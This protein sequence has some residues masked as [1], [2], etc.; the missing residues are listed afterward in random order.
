MI[1]YIIIVI[2]I[3]FFTGLHFTRK[4]D[5]GDK[6]QVLIRW[7][8]FYTLLFLILSFIPFI[9]LDHFNSAKNYLATSAIGVVKGCVAS[10]SG[11]N[12]SFIPKEIQCLKENLIHPGQW[13]INIG[14]GVT[15]VYPVYKKL[16]AINILIKNTKLEIKAKPE[17]KD[18]HSQLKELNKQLQD[19]HNYWVVFSNSQKALLSK[20]NNDLGASLTTLKD[21]IPPES[22]TEQLKT[23][24]EVIEKMKAMSTQIRSFMDATY[25]PP[26]SY[27]IHGGLVVPLY[28]VVLAIMGGI[29][30]MMRKIPEIQKYVAIKGQN[31][32][33]ENL[34]GGLK[35]R[36]KLI[37]QILQVL[38]APMI[39]VT[40]FYQVNPNNLGS[41][42]IL[43]FVSGFASETILL[44]IRAGTDK[45]RKGLKSEP[46][47][48]TV[49]EDKPRG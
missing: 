29:V 30:S 34:E 1:A 4:L 26:D 6:I 12:S 21:L 10:S 49:I 37:F 41:I 19:F 18:L 13:L 8:Y 31:I 2:L 5:N 16:S 48:L 45:M 7:S 36:E 28:F 35:A 40:A 17:K 43:G 14:G 25:G 9:L 33:G 38:S 46:A 15:P 39:A 27:R 3:I 11:E 47:E 22:N 23:S 32:Q 42:V 44:M 24:K 20:L